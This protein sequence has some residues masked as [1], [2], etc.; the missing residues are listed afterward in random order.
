MID[1][2]RC[3]TRSP[4]GA[5][6][7]EVCGTELPRS[8]PGPARRRTISVVAVDPRTG[9]GD[10][11]A[12]RAQATRIATIV[13]DEAQR[14]GATVTGLAPD[15][16]LALLGVPHALEDDAARAI[17]L[18]G[19]IELAL[20]R[21]GLASGIAV[22]TGEAVIGEAVTDVSGEAITSAAARAAFAQDGKPDIDDAT[23]Q[24]AEARARRAGSVSP[25]IARETEIDLLVA[26][27]ERCVQARSPHRVIVTG[28][29]G[30]GKS[31]LIAEFTAGL[32]PTTSVVATACPP[33]GESSTF[34][35]LI[36]LVRDLAGDTPEDIAA[37]LGDAEDAAL[38][39]DHVFAM[40]MFGAD[41]SIEATF[42]GL[43]RF[44]EAAARPRP[45][46]IVIED[47]HWAAPALLDAIDHLTDLGHDA[48]LLIVCSGREDLVSTRPDWAMQRGTNSH[49][50][51]GPLP[52]DS[53][54][55][56]VRA[57]AGAP[58]DEAALARIREVTGGNPFFV[59]ELV[60]SLRQQGALRDVG[61]TLT[62]SGSEA[63]VIPE[64][65]HALLESRIDALPPGE[66]DALAI[67]SVV[68]PSFEVTTI[69]AVAS[70]KVGGLL[71]RL[72]AKGLIVPGAGTQPGRDSFS[73]RH[74]S[75]RDV[76]YASMTRLERAVVHEHLAGRLEEAGG[77]PGVVG[78][79]LEHAYRERIQLGPHNDE[80][81]AIGRRAADA[82]TVAAR[83]AEATGDAHAVTDLLMRACALPAD[84]TERAF[85]LLD[86]TD[87][88]MDAGDLDSPQVLLADRSLSA[89]EHV[90]AAALVQKARLDGQRSF[91]GV[92]W[93]EGIADATLATLHAAGDDVALARAHLRIAEIHWDRLDCA[94]TE[95]ALQHTVTHADA[96][97]RV[98]LM[99]RALSWR[100]S[101]LL[102]GPVPVAEALE[103]CRAI[104][105]DL[106]GN[107]RLEA[108]VHSR[109]AVL[110][111]MGGDLDGARSLMALARQT[112]SQLGQH[113]SLAASSQEAGTIEMIAGDPAAAE[114]E[115]R[116]G[117]EQLRA[118]N[119]R[120]YMGTSA[121][122]LAEALYEL[123][124]LQ[125]AEEYARL[126][127]AEAG[128]DDSSKPDWAPVLA[129]VTAFAGDLAGAVTLA[130]EALAAA[131]GTDMLR[132]QAL[133]HLDLAEVLR[134]A[135]K[136][137]EAEEHIQAAIALF[138]AKGDIVSGARAR[139]L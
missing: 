61:G 101:C 114:S 68:G 129:K 2:V 83:R 97:G 104:V 57:A 38:V 10:V 27:Y 86:L 118:M 111:A 91:G 92:A 12:Q 29:P 138:D 78:Y 3:G 50:A 96:A 134:L 109:A 128:D 85:R 39:T 18:A 58:V 117:L 45:L 23:R 34:R 102:W 107:L 79:H 99:S 123:G 105:A 8:Q 41:A 53:L 55:E 1:C 46:V 87:A 65:V 137:A 17:E 74:G 7:C 110:L 66:R 44:F 22:A 135:D 119:D 20:A 81:E 51:L 71:G 100:S 112:L 77:D 25:F 75:I 47:T 14:L 56:L 73:F 72:A 115:F 26:A 48:S 136:P 124:R 139:A 24:R 116:L 19:A 95:Q 98:D 62:L 13:E 126:A 15:R 106:S 120:S 122:F 64:S 125:E 35:P 108:L 60:A 30:T 16:V 9:D 69:E 4:Q 33:T 21:A 36:R 130:R 67:A 31:R 42:W 103:R 131:G 5:R 84:E 59:E 70:A 52:Q 43:R 93:F 133:A 121:A 40:L 6:F 94:A 132:V 88:M 63:L 54:A 89:D 127:A 37:L 90:A 11:E 82:L 113:L 28:P 49:I 32:P 80:V 76:A